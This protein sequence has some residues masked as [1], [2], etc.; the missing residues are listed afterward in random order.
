VK[1]GTKTKELNR[2]QSQ[3]IYRNC[4]TPK[5]YQEEGGGGVTFQYYRKFFLFDFRGDPVRL[6]FGKEICHSLESKTQAFNRQSEIKICQRS[7]GNL[8]GVSE[9]TTT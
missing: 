9:M 5:S 8:F 7:R 6:V 2:I 4:S 3:N 1:I